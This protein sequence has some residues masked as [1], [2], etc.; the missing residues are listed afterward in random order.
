MKL[1]KSKPNRAFAWLGLELKDS[2]PSWRVVCLNR[3]CHQVKRAP[4][5]MR[6][7]LTAMYYLA[8][9]SFPAESCGALQLHSCLMH[10]AEHAEK[11]R[12]MLNILA[13]RILSVLH[14]SIC[15]VIRE[16]FRV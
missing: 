11:T 4:H 10:I 12:E 13:V 1:I 9:R 5:V 8:S 7:F 15:R 3:L 16:I 6:P 2:W 14:S